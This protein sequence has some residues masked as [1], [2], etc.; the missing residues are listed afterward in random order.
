MQKS[1][2]FLH[3]G[4]GEKTKDQTPFRELD[5]KEIRLD[6]NKNTK[7]DII[8]TML[9][10]KDVKDQSVDA[11]F[12][13]HNIEHVYPHEVEIA[14]KEFRRVIKDTGFLLITCPD[15]QSICSL[16]ADNKLTEAAYTSLAGPIT[17]LD[18]IYGHRS[19]IARGEHFM[20]H[21]CGFTATTLSIDIQSAGF[22][23]A[24]TAKGQLFDLWALGT[25]SKW[26]EPEVMNVC[27]KL[28]KN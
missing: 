28:F 17:P 19:S 18:M 25:C 6:I 15:L 5:W 22:A 20:A 3:V 24:A 2:I 26:E 21:K 7:P 4:C 11:V 14:L 16:V 27:K 23:Q 1:G 9:N 8:G 13:S 10:M 12:S